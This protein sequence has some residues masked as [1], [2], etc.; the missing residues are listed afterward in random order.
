MFVYLGP[1]GLSVALKSFPGFLFLMISFLVYNIT[2]LFEVRREFLQ[3]LLGK[4]GHGRIVVV[5]SHA[6]RLF[7][8]L[9]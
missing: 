7:A 5:D 6:R 4:L 9:N 2:E 8:S 3:V 1:A